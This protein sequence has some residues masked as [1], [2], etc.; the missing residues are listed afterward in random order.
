[1]VSSAATAVASALVTALLAASLV[2]GCGR[3]PTAPPPNAEIKVAKAVR[4]KVQAPAEG[5]LVTYRVRMPEARAHRVEIE[6]VFPAASAT[7]RTLMIPVWTPGSYLVRDYAKHIEWA[8][9]VSMSGEA[10]PLQKTASNRFEVTTKPGESFAL[11]YRLYARDLSVRTNFVDADFALFAG[12]ATFV[13]EVG[14]LERTHVVEIDVPS[15]YKQCISSMEAPGFALA[16]DDDSAA[17]PSASKDGATSSSKDDAPSVPEGAVPAEE[18]VAQADEV[19]ADARAE[20]SKRHAAAH[21]EPRQARFAAGHF[22]ELVDSP[23]ACGTP[24][25]YEFE[26][27]GVPHVIANFGEDD[28]WD[29]AR[30]AEDVKQ[31]VEAH[32]DFWKSIPYPRYVFL[33]FLVEDGY[34]GLEHKNSTAMIAKRNAMEDRD[35]Y[36]TWLGLVSHEFFHTWNVKRLRPVELGPFDYEHQVYTRSLWVAEGLT[37]YY[38][39]LM[40]VRARLM[41]REEYLARLSKQVASVQAGEGRLVQSLSD[42]SF[43]AWIKYYQPDENSVNATVSYYRKGALAGFL[44]DAQLR[45]QSGGGRTLDHVLRN[46]YA[47]YSETKGYTQ[48]EF[49]KVVDEVAGRDLAGFFGRHVDGTQEMDFEIALGLYGLKFEGD[50]TEGDE[51]LPAFLG[52]TVDPK[53]IVQEVTLNSPAFEAGLNVGHEL[54]AIDQVRIDPSHLEVA[55]KRF[56]A[57]QEVALTIARRG[58]LEQLK[59]TLGAPKHSTWTLTERSDANLTQRA[60]WAGLLSPNQPSH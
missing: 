40:L 12:A 16:A 45:A 13:T 24:S 41:E 54:I 1:M 21:A 4:T 11:R 17:A 5:D 56:N 57:D 44:L 14:R 39:D 55:L 47:Q 60:R 59:A 52:V 28:R 27:E 42:A 53:G 26:V 32:V 7:K 30:A 48:D 34:G 51:R 49:R 37:S 46:A 29:G 9:A 8:E 50:T 18:A 15:E 10:L 20:Q 33:N 19:A 2:S 6:A 36:L 38:D 25:L 31:L 23:I 3:R 43:D 22:D 35:S 58:Q